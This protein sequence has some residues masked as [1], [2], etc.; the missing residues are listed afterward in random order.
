MKQNKTILAFIEKEFDKINIK[1]DILQLRKIRGNKFY[2]GYIYI[3][4]MIDLTD[5]QNQ[6]INDNIYNELI[7]NG[8]EILF[9]EFDNRSYEHIKEEEFPLVETN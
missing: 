5:K 7:N 6:Y 4:D 2:R 3:Y 1:Y 8:W 9:T